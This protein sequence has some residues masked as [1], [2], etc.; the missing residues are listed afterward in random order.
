M[1]TVLHNCIVQFLVVVLMLSCDVEENAPV[2]PPTDEY[3]I[4]G[5]TL[6]KQGKLEGINHTASGTAS[7]YLKDGLIT[8][9]LDPYSSENGPDL[10]IYLSKDSGASEYIR[11]GNLKSTMGKQSY[12][13]PSMT[14]ID[15]FDFVHVWCEKYSV[16][17]ARAEVK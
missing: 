2:T 17:F 1:K 9:L 12:D 11:L 10:K 14:D 16:E 6:L 5:A 8:V 4:N 7:I 15:Q 13:V 3:D